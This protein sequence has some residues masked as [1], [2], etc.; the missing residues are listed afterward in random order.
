MTSGKPHR[1][2]R[3]A[4]GERSAVVG[5]VGQFALAA[6]LVYA[7][8]GSLEWIRVADP[9]AGVA[10]DFQFKA[11]SSRHA[12]Q[13]KSSQFPSTFTWSDFLSATGDEPSLLG[14]LA[15][16][17][18]RIRET[19]DGPL[20]VHLCSNN[21]P[22]TSTPAAGS[23]LD[24][25]T[26]SGPKHFASFIK[27]S[28]E[29]TQ[30][31]LATE[32][33]DLGSLRG[34]P[35]FA[36]WASA[37]QVIQDATKLSDDEFVAF[38]RD[39]ELNLGLSLA[40]EGSRSSA[41]TLIEEHSADDLKVLAW[42][43][44]ELV[45]DA[46]RPVHVDR[47]DLI[48]RLGWQSRLTFSNRHQFPVPGTY[49]TNEAAETAIQDAF[50]QLS[51]GYLALIGP[52]GSGKSTLLS[53]INIPGRVVRYYA[54]VPDS[55]DPLSG[56]GEAES[57]LSDLSLALHEAGLSRRS[58]P[59]GLPNLRAAV[60]EQLA[61]AAEVWSGQGQRTVIVIDGLDH[62]PR[63]QNP[64]R[65]MLE[66]L[67]MPNAI[68]D[69]VFVLLGSQA[70]N[71]LP[72][73]ILAA[74][75][76]DE[77]RIIELAPLSNREV[78]S[79]AEQSALTSWMW[80]G[81]IDK[82][83]EV[84][85]GHPL[86]LAYLLEELVRIPGAELDANEQ[87]L[88][89]D[90]VLTHASQYGGDVEQRYRG[91]FKAVSDDTELIDLLGKVARLR[92][93]LN[94]A[95]IRE[96]V[97]P[98]VVGRF[99]AATRTFF[100]CEGEEWQFI[101][102]SF[103]RFLI[104]ESA[105]VGGHFD[106][107]RDRSIHAQLAEQCAAVGDNWPVYRDEEIAHRF[108][109]EQYD[110]VIQVATPAKLRGR[111]TEL[112][113][114]STVSDH[115]G[116]ALRAAAESDQRDAYVAL[117][118]FSSELILRNQVL[119]HE[120]LVG[121]LAEVLHPSDVLDHVVRA[122][123]LL[124][125][126]SSALKH[127]A[128]WA[129]DGHLKAAAAVLNACNGLADLDATPLRVQRSEPIADWA[130]ATLGVSGLE[131]VL[132]QLDR[133]RPLPV[134]RRA[135][136][137][138]EI[139]GS[140][141]ASP[142]SRRT[143]DGGEEELRKTLKHRTVALAR[144]VDCLVE[145]RDDQSLDRL[146]AIIDRESSL[147]W[148][149]RTR[150]VRAIAAMKDGLISEVMRWAREILELETEEQ[151]SSAI[152]AS[153]HD[154]GEDRAA[155]TDEEE[156]DLY[157]VEYTGSADEAKT[158]AHADSASH[159]SDQ[160]TPAGQRRLA[161]GL[162]L[163]TA[164]VLVE[165]GLHD[166]PELGKLIDDGE[167]ASTADDLSGEAMDPY[168]EAVNLWILKNFRNSAQS[169]NAGVVGRQGGALP[170]KLPI[171]VDGAPAK[172]TSVDPAT[173]VNRTRQAGASAKLTEM[174]NGAPENPARSSLPKHGKEAGNLRFLTALRTLADAHA[175]HLAYRA[176]I[177]TEPPVLAL[178]AEQIL[179]IREVPAEQ[180]R[181]WTGWYRVRE[182]MPELLEN[183]I[184]LSARSGGSAELLRLARQFDSAWAGD[185]AQYW[186]VEVQ[187]AALTAFARVDDAAFAWIKGW[188]DTI[189]P[190]IDTRGYDPASQVDA[191]LQQAA[192]R[193]LVGQRS[194]ALD[195]V[196][197]AVAAAAS[198]GHLDDSEQLAQWIDWLVAARDF[199][200]VS[201]EQFIEA[202]TVF[203]SRLLGASHQDETAASTAA[204]RLVIE[205]WPVSPG[206][207]RRV[208]TALCE[209]GVLAEA[210]W[211]QAVVLA[212]C[213]D[214]TVDPK[215]LALVT[216]KLLLPIIKHPSNSLRPGFEERGDAEA[217]AVLDLGF[218]TWTVDGPFAGSLT[219]PRRGT[220]SP[221]D[222]LDADV[223]PAIGYVPG[224]E[225][226]AGSSVEPAAAWPRPLSSPTGFLSQLR[227]VPT[228]TALSASWWAEAAAGPLEEAP[229]SSPVAAA[230]LEQAD[231]LNPPAAVFGKIL[232]IAAGCGHLERA[233]QALK[234][235][236]SRLPGG[237][238]SRY[239]DGGS[240]REL[241]EAVLTVEAP[242]LRTLALRDLAESITSQSL[243]WSMTGD[244]KNVLEVVAGPE[245]VAGAWPTVEAYLDIFA[246]ATTAFV[247]AEDEAGR[248]LPD[249]GTTALMT[250]VADFLDHP[251]RAPQ[252]AA[253]R[254]LAA[255][256][257][258]AE[259]AIF[260]LLVVCLSFV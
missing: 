225:A 238:W 253:Q 200:T 29:P 111:L 75:E 208:G 204:E 193:G 182:A 85:E 23:P 187:Q 181:E 10:D 74:L 173:I 207:A 149:A 6:K 166:A 64:I 56:R 138:H 17:W 194:E 25:A 255:S 53:N 13:V 65:S 117:A 159:N 114:L 221:L 260:S 189:D 86:A 92:T 245:A 151:L 47:E 242:E 58:Q 246:P 168:R 2:T 258:Y 218:Q 177:R 185:R 83:I 105:K 62:V 35:A 122:G 103:R 157:E 57:F 51:G 102:N 164:L 42:T 220:E 192:I 97:P 156:V 80:P 50:S 69:G 43:F 113:A 161:L 46:S 52:A 175:Q 233:I 20:R 222:P 5:F 145:V 27:Q 109:A 249:T 171:A 68:G 226:D 70:T 186:P 34:T 39:F 203:A 250:L 81:Q 36:S 180:A 7:H 176:G 96:W 155:L 167:T 254:I 31:I 152:S 190:V 191:W 224:E 59:V 90:K 178:C 89:A 129:S 228:P 116:V 95:W 235:R 98:G 216:T 60:Q 73:P 67:P 49:A 137:S 236:L 124:I 148:R 147:S 227:R 130:E 215:F 134:R 26:V 214:K 121:T 76:G 230:I 219:T 4:D 106:V 82:L 202:G 19:W 11:G 54:F 163:K 44:Q 77:Q 144:C 132:T 179:R 257:V 40:E 239:Y 154:P 41:G 38:L 22:Q 101:H 136:D 128:R 184:S 199:G 197:S 143:E 37:W 162:R 188:L 72:Q 33:R 32:L 1:V 8:L 28:L 150:I 94:I 108:L 127:A 16:A 195:A 213:T 209:A 112:H 118:L 153:P 231:R 88:A 24:L 61:L 229:I 48:V 126:A 212:A 165:A 104:D 170:A 110:I 123:K 217:L 196:R 119:E 131:A 45:A 66:E 223:T 120:K 84:S 125:P 247:M 87:R 256:L 3:P 252:E 9:E 30:S 169:R 140:G 18:K 21:F 15:D 251:A 146:M 211:I 14:K 210:D 107:Q 174:R 12:L 55:P 141:E 234:S 158:L 71:I 93:S 91:Y 240:R 205:I 237:G 206:A 244:L 63:E 133:Y 139:R 198:V 79:L 241:F 115:T 201:A 142:G 99:V 172:A 243:H 183:L 135:N 160:P 78:R 100:R 232:A 259:D 248:S